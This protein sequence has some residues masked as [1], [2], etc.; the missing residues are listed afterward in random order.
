[1]A[2]GMCAFPHTLCI[3]KALPTLPLSLISGVSFSREPPKAALCLHRTV[4]TSIWPRTPHHTW[5]YL[6][7][8][9]QG[10]QGSVC[11]WH[12]SRTCIFCWKALPS[13]SVC[14]TQIQQRWSCN[15]FRVEATM[16]FQCFLLTD[17]VATGNY[18]WDLGQMLNNCIPHINART[19]Q[20]TTPL[21]RL[22][23][24]PLSKGENCLKRQPIPF[25]NSSNG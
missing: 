14:I 4:E 25:L 13:Y 24:Q 18:F 5:K 9:A 8:L 20:I 1:M 2:A 12:I 17:V 6:P 22:A 16:L 21:H 3:W 23:G 11:H 19:L 7:D 10:W 15:Y